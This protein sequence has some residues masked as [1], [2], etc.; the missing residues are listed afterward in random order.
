MLESIISDFFEIL[1]FIKIFNSEIRG[2]SFN[3]RYKS[4]LFRYYF[5]LLD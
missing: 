3:K 4:N 5:I 2:E 1:D